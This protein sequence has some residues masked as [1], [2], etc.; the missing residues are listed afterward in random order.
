MSWVGSIH[1]CLQTTA[2]I[3]FKTLTLL[4]RRH[5]MSIQLSTVFVQS[6]Q[7]QISSLTFLN[8]QLGWRGFFLRRSRAGHSFSILL[9]LFQR[10]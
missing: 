10:E 5:D 6:M 9:L 4:Y 2:M 1:L 7:G 8:S 3:Q